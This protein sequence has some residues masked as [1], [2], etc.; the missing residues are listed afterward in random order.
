MSSRPT[1]LSLFAGIGGLD[2]G[3]ERAGWRCVGQVEI[4]PFCRKVLAKHWPDV[5]KWSDIREFKGDECERPDLICG[6]FPCQDVSTAGTMRGIGSGTRTG[7]YREVLRIAGEIRPKFILLE[8]VAGLFVDGRIGTVLGDLA[9]IGFDSEWDCIPAAAVGAHHIR[10]RVFILAYSKR[11][12]WKDDLCGRNPGIM[13]AASNATCHEG[14]KKTTVI[15]GGC[16]GIS[17]WSDSEMPRADDSRNMRSRPER[18]ALAERW[19]DEPGMDRMADGV[20]GWLD[21]YRAI[22]NA[23]V[24]QVAE[25]IGRRILEA[26]SAGESC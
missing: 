21:R 4:D 18:P 3:L 19:M 23:V 7:L 10:D 12:K 22:G 14:A 20:P 25:W 24:P 13:V 15:A 6:G 26:M 2:L 16:E 11:G 5:Q 8:N 17:I 9:E 1:F